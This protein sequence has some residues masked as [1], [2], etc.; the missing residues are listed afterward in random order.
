MSTPTDDLTPA[1]RTRWDRVLRLIGSVVNPASGPSRRRVAVDGYQDTDLFAGRLSEFLGSTAIVAAGGSADCD[2][3]VWLR[4][5]PV[6]TDRDRVR[7]R[8]D[9]VV[10][11]HD[12]RWPVVRFVRPEWTDKETWY[13]TEI[14]AFFAARAARWD[15]RF[16]DD[17]PA[18]AHAVASAAIKPGSVVADVGCGTGRALIP[19]RDA[20]GPD[21]VVLGLDV[22]AE[23][24]DVA[25]PAA[26]S[27][28]AGL[29]LADAR[30]LPLRDGCLDVTFTAG[31]ITHLPDIVAGLAELA[32][33]TR[34]GGRLVLFH[35][36]GRTA[37]AARHGRT[38]MPGEPLDEESLRRSLTTAG[39]R[40][41]SYAD[42]PTHFLALASRI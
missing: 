30:S 29:I 2:V 5:A 24:L 38:V 27:V 10:D 13:L 17:G 9:V 21:G 40:L 42:P 41:D 8:A 39:W 12:V 3:L 16:G 7:D 33:I 6:E 26:A 28:H 37:L 1:Q 22:T 36:S 15:R 11:L 35:P 14:Q 23:M 20:V 31:L 19:L 18:Y 4:T 32:R 25:R 34:S